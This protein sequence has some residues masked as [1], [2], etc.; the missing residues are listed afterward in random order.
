MYS[1]W[2]LVYTTIGGDVVWPSGA[3][4]DRINKANQK[5]AKTA[6]A[7]SLKLAWNWAEK[8]GKK[9]PKLNKK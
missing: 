6:E 4:V 7:K 9:Y 5:F 1:V 3:E 2:T 8:L